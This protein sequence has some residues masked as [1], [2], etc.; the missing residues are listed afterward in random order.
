MNNTHVQ[1]YMCPN[2]CGRKYKYKG[3]LSQHLRYECGVEQQFSCEVCFRKFVHRFHLKKHY[4]T[5][6]KVLV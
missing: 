6:H 4:V 3:G 2:E 1:F 5:V